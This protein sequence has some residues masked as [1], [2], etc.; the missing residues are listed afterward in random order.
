MKKSKI[1]KE[2]FQRLE[3]LL[4][5]VND[6]VQPLSYQDELRSL[7]DKNTRQNLYSKFP[8]CFIPYNTGNADGMLFPVCNRMGA[9]D[10]FIIKFSMKLAN[11]IAGKEQFDKGPIEII[12]K[13]LERLHSKY[14][15]DNVKTPEM[16]GQ[17]GNVTKTLNTIKNYLDK[18]KDE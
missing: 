17:K 9:V 7:M 16:A 2:E 5:K 11:K 14:S 4:G 1:F 13:R 15:G 18:L 10:P 6:I 8:K 12:L 3:E